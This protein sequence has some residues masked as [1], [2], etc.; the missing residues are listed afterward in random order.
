MLHIFLFLFSASVV[1]MAV[2]NIIKEKKFTKSAIVKIIIS[3]MLLVSCLVDIFILGL[4][5]INK[6]TD[7]KKILGYSHNPRSYILSVMVD[8]D[9][10][11]YIASDLLK[12]NFKG[13]V[14][15]NIR[16]TYLPC[17]R[18]VIKLEQKPEDSHN[19]PLVDPAVI[20]DDG[21]R[22]LYDFSR[23]T[24][25]FTIATIGIFLVILLIVRIIRSRKNDEPM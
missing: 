20:S 21:Y 9:G 6:L 22:E 12:N 4:G 5:G 7:L 17:T 15:E 13:E 24:L 14:Y 10:K 3:V 16:V 1:G 8:N 11:L 23:D 18:M 2:F 19:I 25:P